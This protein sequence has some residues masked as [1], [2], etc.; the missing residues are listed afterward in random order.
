MSEPIRSLS[1]DVA[2]ESNPPSSGNASDGAGSNCGSFPPALRSLS[3]PSVARAPRR[4]YAG[5]LLPLEYVA[6]VRPQVTTRCHLP[7]RT[8]G[9]GGKSYPARRQLQQPEAG[10]IAG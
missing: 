10:A 7:E 6:T 9:R 4:R 2:V 1:Y 5:G 3:C 8:L